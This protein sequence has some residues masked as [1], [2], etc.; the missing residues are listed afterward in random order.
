[1]PRSPED[2]I[3]EIRAANLYRVAR[4]TDSTRHLTAFASN[5][6]LGLAD[7]ELLRDVFREA[8]VKYGAGSGA[9]RLIVG[10]QPAHEELEAEIADFKRTERALS[11]STGYAAAVGTLTSVLAKGDVVILDKLC[12]A[13]LIDGARLSGATMRVFPHNDLKKLEHH[14]NWANDQIE[15]SGR[16]LVVT[17]SVFSMDGDLAP[18]TEIARLKSQ[19][20]ALLMIDEAHAVG[21]IGPEG[22]GLAEKLGLAGEIDLQMGTLSKAIGVSG[23]YVAANEAWIELLVNR[24]R[25]FIY[26]TAPPPAVAATAAES[27]RQI[28]AAEGESRRLR[29]WAH[30]RHFDTEIGAAEPS[31]SPIRPFLVGDSQRALKLSRSLEEQGLLVPAIRFPTVPRGTERLRI[32]LSTSHDGEEITRLARAL[33]EVKNS[34]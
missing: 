19:A 20:G 23:G 29:L 8:A 25:S 3:A 26:S 4:S 14:L 27:I 15:E 28:R 32:S 33:V 30:I 18:L 22:R 9:S 2:E 1:M 11:F 24:A 34:N 17:E 5:D 12:H 16:I 7:S 21:V 10:T 6:Y 13:S 31:E